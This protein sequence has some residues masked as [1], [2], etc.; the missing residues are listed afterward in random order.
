MSILLASVLPSLFFPVPARGGTAN[1]APRPR[2]AVP[3]AA[4][5]PRMTAD[6]SDPAWDSAARITAFAPCLQEGKPNLPPPGTETE[7]RTA[8]DE[9]ALYV[10][11]ICRGAPPYTPEKGRNA[12]LYKGDAVE[13]FLDPVG[14]AREWIELQGN[15]NGDLFQQLFLCTGETAPTPYLRLREDV[16]RREVWAFPGWDIPGLRTAASRREIPGV[17]GAPARV[18]WIVDFLLPAGPLLK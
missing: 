13:I 5:P 4:M 1:D 16:I 15:A 12:P 6:P 18:E 3:H 11:F 14:D 17:A 10:R 7:V 9:G 2:L 8:W